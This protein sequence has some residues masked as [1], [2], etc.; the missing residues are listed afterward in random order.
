[1]IKDKYKKLMDFILVSIFMALIFSIIP[2][3]CD[4]QFIIQDFLFIHSEWQYRSLVLDS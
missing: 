1:M 4:F 2:L 3:F